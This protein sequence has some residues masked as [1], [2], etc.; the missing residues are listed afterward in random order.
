MTILPL[1]DYIGMNISTIFG[2]R[3]TDLR[4]LASG[5]LFGRV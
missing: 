3:Y 4:G 1:G 2:V 5:I